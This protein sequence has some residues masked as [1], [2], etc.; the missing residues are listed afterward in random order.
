MS[1]ADRLYHSGE[2]YETPAVDSEPAPLVVDVPTGARMLCLSPSM[3]RKLI[4]QG[5][6]RSCKIGDRRLLPVEALREFVAQRA[7]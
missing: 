3:V 1:T 7:A 6:L 4:R 5:E 2:T